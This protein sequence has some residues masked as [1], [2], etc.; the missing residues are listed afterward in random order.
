MKV[1]KAIVSVVLCAALAVSLIALGA[2]LCARGLV[3]GDGIQTALDSVDMSQALTGSERL[4]ALAEFASPPEDALETLKKSVGSVPLI[5]GKSTVVA[6]VKGEGA[7]AATEAG[8]RAVSEFLKTNNVLRDRVELNRPFADA[9]V[10]YCEQNGL[11]SPGLHTDAVQE[12]LNNFGSFMAVAGN[13]GGGLADVVI[14]GKRFLVMLTGE[15]AEALQAYVDNACADACDSAVKGELV[16][17]IEYALTGESGVEDAGEP[18]RLSA[19]I[20]DALDDAQRIY[21]FEIIDAN[22]IIKSAADEYVAQR[23]T[24]A[25]DALPLDADAVAALIGERG[26]STVRVALGDTAFYAVV[27]ASAV[28]AV[29]LI[30]LWLKRGGFLAWLGSALALAGAALLY[31]R[32]LVETVFGLEGKLAL[33]DALSPLKGIGE[34]ARALVGSLLGGAAQYG[35]IALIA[36]LAL[37]AAF[38]V[39]SLLTR[40]KKTKKAGASDSTA[41]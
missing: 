32:P 2:L 21:S 17:V 13:R 37:L 29:V 11:L 26:L 14:G 18:A 40:K 24:P 7:K 41:R 36:A 19:I 34:V 25:L 12:A 15:R 38:L 9:Y 28:C 33:I 3:D 4:A 39:I 1:L 16:S 22:G 30:V 35:K 23:I 20:T 10:A 31:A 8:W 27:A 6:T 5:L